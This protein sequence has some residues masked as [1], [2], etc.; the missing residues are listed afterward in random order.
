MLVKNLDSIF[1]K[2]VRLNAAD[3]KGNVRC[4]TSGKTYNWKDIQAGHFISRRHYALRW[5]ERNVKP[6]SKAENIFNQ[7]NAPVFAQKLISEY[8]SD[9]IDLL[10]MKKNNTFHLER[11]V[12]QAM[13]EDYTD[14]VE[15]LKKEKGL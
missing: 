7:G 15:K 8:G 13:I 2:W 5:D 14:K 6:Q 4:Y 1:S 10:L 3:K 9:I 12:L 11:F